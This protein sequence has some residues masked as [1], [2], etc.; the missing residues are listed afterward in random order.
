MLHAPNPDAD[1]LVSSAMPLPAAPPM[2]PKPQTLVNF[3]QNAGGMRDTNGDLVSLGHTRFPGLVTNKGLDP[4]LM[5]EMAH[6]SRFLGDGTSNSIGE[7]TVQDL[8]DKLDQHPTY[9][10][11]D[12]DVVD[13]WNA[14]NDART[15]ED[16]SRMTAAEYRAR[17]TG[18]DGSTVAPSTVPQTRADLLHEVKKE[19]DKAIEYPDEAALGLPGGALKTGQARLKQA[20][21]ALNDA[22]ETQ[23]PGYAE[24]NAASSALAKRGEAVASGSKLLRADAPWPDRVATERAA[25]E[26]GERAAQAMG[27]RGAMEG[28]IR[29]T[30]N[31]ITAGKYIIGGEGDFNRDTLGHVF[32]QEPTQNFVGAVDRE[33]KF[34]DTAARILGNSETAPRAQAIKEM[35]PF[36]VGTVSSIAHAVSKGVD[37]VAGGALEKALGDVT[38]SYP[39]VAK[40][41]SSNGGARDAYVRAL[42]ASETR[43]GASAVTGQKIGNRSALVAALL[44][45]GATRPGPSQR[46]LQ[47]NSR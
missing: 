9:S 19:L 15:G 8:L 4:D 42:R 22:L 17:F 3:I 34:A 32:G 28:K 7:T 47:G 24:A 37:K 21:F 29:N 39:E 1:A 45:N 2:P 33:R 16:G 36:R 20:R 43:S 18:R 6:E 14:A 13:A 30:A 23:V 11:H 27:L 41:L 40:I 10:A 35:A 25:M 12:Q 5:R 46:R 31:D 26:P 44:A 38:K